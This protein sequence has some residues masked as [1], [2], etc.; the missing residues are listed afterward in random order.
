MFSEKD[1]L[2]LSRFFKDPAHATLIVRPG[3]FSVEEELFLVDK[4]LGDKYKNNLIKAQNS[5]GKNY[6]KVEDLRKLSASL[7]LRSKKG[8]E[9]RLVLIPEDVRIEAKAQN[10]LLK[11][12]EEPPEGVFFIL[13][14]SR[15][16]VFLP[17]ISS[18]CSLIKLKKPNED[19][20][21]S[22][23]SKNL[24]LTESQAKA[25]WLQAGGSS[26]DLANILADENLKKYVLESLSDAKK[27]L[28][29]KDYEKLV[30]LKN[31]LSKREDALSFLNALLV[32]LEIFI[33]KNTTSALK[34][35]PLVD[36]VEF[37]HKAI[38]ANANVRIQLLSLV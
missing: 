26:R 28:G 30:A 8:G 17:T 16:G 34:L 10:T 23:I 4:L 29:S 22:E 3:G 25:L 36:K 31:R 37:A 1:K 35:K 12:F 32:I 21:A 6:I 33:N 24:N 7:D 9:R 38:K 14:S 18:R 27:F 2:N 19:D 20:A 15:E 11:I 13:L 5:E